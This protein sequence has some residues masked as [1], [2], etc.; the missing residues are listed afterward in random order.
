VIHSLI[1]VLRWA[2]SSWR[3]SWALSGGRSSFTVS[4]FSLPLK[5]NGG[6]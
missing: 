5:G 6:R 2:A 1:L 3:M 4:L